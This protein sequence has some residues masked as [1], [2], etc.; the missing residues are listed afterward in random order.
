MLASLQRF[1][2]LVESR[3]Q[4]FDALVAATNLDQTLSWTRNNRLQGFNR[5]AVRLR[6]INEMAK[7]F[8][9]T[10]FVET[11]TYHAATSICAHRCLGL[12]VWSCELSRTK[13]WVAKAVT[14]G[15]GGIELARLDSRSFLDR[16]VRKLRHRTDM[17]AMFYLDAHGDATCPLMEE[18]ALVLSLDS[19]V[20]IIDD[21]AVPASEFISRRYGGFEL[22]VQSIRDTLS[23]SGVRRVFFP[24]YPA[25]LET[26]QGR[27]GYTVF[28]RSAS[29]EQEMGKAAFPLS[30][31]SPFELS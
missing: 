22:C 1:L 13:H 23:L 31:L 9:A 2:R 29:L 19:F 16:V 10:H 28:F 17:L 26:G 20:A 3:R 8:G 24:N 25:S 21:F 27:A 11:G 12:P 14:L 18:L 4:G 5:S 6:I 30:L 7:V 15:M